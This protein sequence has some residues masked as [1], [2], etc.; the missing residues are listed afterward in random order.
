[1]ISKKAKDLANKRAKDR[2]EI[3]EETRF[4]DIK[5]ICP[6]CASTNIKVIVPWFSLQL[7]LVC[8]DCGLKRK[9]VPHESLYP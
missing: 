6:H 7:T 2:E 5:G 8:K 3:D 9:A 1:M 4:M